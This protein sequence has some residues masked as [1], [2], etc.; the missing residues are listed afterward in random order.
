MRSTAR[1]SDPS[2]RAATPKRSG[3]RTGCSA[4]PAGESSDDDR[5][6]HTLP[7]WDEFLAGTG[8]KLDHAGRCKDCGRYYRTAPKPLTVGQL[9]TFIGELDPILTPE[10]IAG[11]RAYRGSQA[12]PHPLRTR[13][14]RAVEWARRE[15]G[16]RLTQATI[17]EAL[18]I[19]ERN[20]RAF[21]TTPPDSVYVAQALDMTHA[22]AE[23]ERAL[24]RRRF[25]R[26]LADAW[27]RTAGY[28][29]EGHRLIVRLPLRVA[30][31]LLF[32]KPRA[33]SAEEAASAATR[34]AA[35]RAHLRRALGHAAE[36]PLDH[37]PPERP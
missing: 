6:L 31:P 2:T 10:V 22:T 1:S 7:P 26:I 21:W 15:F 30:F 9:I 25:K 20:V 17:V 4:A 23:E 14:A 18:E 11:F 33:R 36:A 3:P 27:H 34:K 32:T 35:M 28:S 12:G 5:P 8:G 29:P 19:D 16:T 37:H 13:I 24:G